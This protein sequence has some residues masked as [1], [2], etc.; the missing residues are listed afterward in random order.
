MTLAAD[1]KAWDAVLVANGDKIS[2]LYGSLQATEPAQNQISSSLDYVE[3]QQKELS[4]ILDSYEKA[5]NDVAGVNEHM[6]GADAEREKS[7]RQAESLNTQLDDLSRSLK[8]LIG[9]VNSLS[10]GAGLTPASSN[11]DAEAAA[12]ANPV[13]QIAAILNAH[14]AGLSHIETS[15]ANLR[16]VVD[17]LEH[18]VSGVS[19][20]T[21]PGFQSKQNQSRLSAASRYRS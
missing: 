6:G 15:T 21:W 12:V 20:G 11:E 10:A 7:Y 2:E 13:A 17:D 1:V 16:R 5:V 14:L 19:V 4:D 18:K 8:G 3:K 9:D